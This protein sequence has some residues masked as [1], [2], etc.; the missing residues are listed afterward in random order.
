MHGGSGVLLTKMIGKHLED[1]T[2]MGASLFVGG[3]VMW[4]IDARF[5][6]APAGGFKVENMEQMSLGRLFG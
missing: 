4:V 3:I 2:V 1:I 5:G 6:N